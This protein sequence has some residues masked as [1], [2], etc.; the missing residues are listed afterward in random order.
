MARWRCQR[1]P[2][3]HTGHACS[4]Q[5]LDREGAEVPAPSEPQAARNRAA[6]TAHEAEMMEGSK[7]AQPQPGEVRPRGGSCVC[8]L[9]L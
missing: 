9:L 7:E 6:A 2:V 1:I 4:W 8:A 5:D 3:S